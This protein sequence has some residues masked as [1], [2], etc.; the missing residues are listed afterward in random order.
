MD[1]PPDWF[2]KRRQN[3]FSK[4]YELV[5]IE[6]PINYELSNDIKFIGYIDV[7]LY[8]KV[9]DRYKIIDIKTSTW[10]FKYIV[11]TRTKHINYY[12]INS[13]MSST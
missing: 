11:L 4:G 9:R 1:Y 6:T 5:G 10:L 2:K 3:Y 12:C 7:L 13:S 8:D